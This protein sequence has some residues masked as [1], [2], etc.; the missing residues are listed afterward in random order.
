MSWAGL[1]PQR[2]GPAER[3]ATPRGDGFADRPGS[4]GIAAATRS[5]A[6]L[7]TGPQAEGSALTDR[8]K[9]TLLFAL[10]LATDFVFKEGRR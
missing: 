7:H 2:M 10:A 5:G 1:L 9:K 6:A 4:A 3:R 8:R